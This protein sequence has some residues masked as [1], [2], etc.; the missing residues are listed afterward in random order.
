[1]HKKYTIFKNKLLI[2]GFGSIG[3]AI[4]PLI[5]RHIEIKPEQVTIITKDEDGMHIANEYGVKLISQSITQLNHE[6]ILNQYLEANDFLL[7]LSVDV[8]SAALIKFCQH[9]EVLYLDTCIEPWAGGY[10]DNQRSPSQ[11]SNYAMREAVLSLKTTLKNKTTSLVT[12]GANPGLVSHFVKQAL[13]NIAK[14]TGVMVQTPTIRQEWAALAQQLSIKVIHIA[15]RDTQAAKQVKRS[16]EFVNTWSI[17]GFISEG[18][19]PAELGWGSHERHWPNDGHHHD[20]GPRCAIYLNRPGAATRVRT[21]TP[22]AGPFHAFLITHTETISIADYFTLKQGD[23][24]S[25]RPTVHFAYHPCDDAV[26]SLHEFAGN[27]WNQQSTQKILFDEIVEGMDE[28]GVLLMGHANNA[29]W[30]GSQ[31]SI[32]QTRVLAPYNNATS[33][34]VAIGALS[35]M[36]WVMENPERGIVE[37]DEID[38]AFILNIAIPYLGDM[39]GKYTDWTP[40]KSREK[41]FPESL[42]HTD[43]W[44]FINM[45]V[46]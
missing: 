2:I 43:P 39:V 7:N 29:Y 44:Q 14:D 28:L 4:L 12:H 27:E 10:V 8:S 34:Q 18:S 33:L 32:N 17:D 37:P 5:F 35:G 13:I 25:Y 45:R 38:Y 31:L 46:A 36:I 30:F 21:W 40:L 24:V 42:D 19:Q 41:L 26:L 1:M 15:E 20:F 9:K 23:S 3:K 22:N 11:R 6:H 16:N